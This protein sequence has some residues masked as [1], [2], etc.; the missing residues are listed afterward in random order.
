M[1][2]DSNTYTSE[3]V[4]LGIAEEVKDGR[5]RITQRNKFSAGETLTVMK[6][7]GRDLAA[8]VTAMWNE[9]GE[10]V[11]SAPHPK[12]TIWLELNVPVQTGDLLRRD[13][14]RE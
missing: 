14:G 5:V 12:E 6:P 1:V 7:D 9:E 3:A 10:R 4:F 8:E 11:P 2:Y 13:T